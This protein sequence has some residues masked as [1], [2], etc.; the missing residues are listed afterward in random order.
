MQQPSFANLDMQG[1][2]AVDNFSPLPRAEYPVIISGHEIKQ[3]KAGTGH[4][5][6]LTLDIIE[7]NGKGRKVFDL[8]NLWHPGET[9]SQI[10]KESLAQILV[11]LDIT[12]GIP[13]NPAELYN[14]PMIVRLGIEVSEQ[15]G[16]KNKVQAYKRYS[17]ASP[18]PASA[19]PPSTGE[20]I[21]ANAQPEQAAA[22]VPGW[23]Q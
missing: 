11:A 9:A 8:L 5:L 18:V 22:S 13:E 4:Y 12:G 1:V 19:T 17:Q 21:P 3:N 23:A 7:G 15:Y 14:K 6:N 16:D 20:Y 2:S 10:A